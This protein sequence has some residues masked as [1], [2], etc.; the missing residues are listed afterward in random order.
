MNFAE[1][2]KEDY[3]EVKLPTD[4]E[5]EHYFGDIEELGE[6]IKLLLEE[7][8]DHEKLKD[9]RRRLNK[10]GE[11]IS[12]EFTIEDAREALSKLANN[13][14]NF[15][16][17][18]SIVKYGIDSDAVQG[19]ELHKGFLETSLGGLLCGDLSPRRGINGSNVPQKKI[20]SFSFDSDSKK[21]ATYGKARKIRNKVH[22]AE[23]IKARK[24]LECI[25]YLFAAYLF[26]V[27]ENKSEIVNNLHNK[28]KLAENFI[29]SIDTSLP[30]TID[31]TLESEASTSYRDEEQSER[32]KIDELEEQIISRRHAAY[33]IHGNPGAGK[34]TLVRELALRMCRRISEDPLSDIPLPIILHANRYSSNESFTNIICSKLQIHEENLNQYAKQ[35]CLVIFIDGINEIRRKHVR[36]SLVEIE[37]IHSGVPNSVLLITSRMKRLFQGIDFKELRLTPFDNKDVKNYLLRKFEDAEVAKSFYSELLEIPRLMELCRNPLLLY[38]LTDV[39]EESPHVPQ[40]RGRLLNEF[41]NRFLERERRLLTPV[42][43]TTVRRVLSKLAYYMQESDSVALPEIEVESKVGEFTSRFQKGL[44]SVDVMDKLNDANLLSEV[45]KDKLGFFHEMVQEYFAALELKNKYLRDEIDLRNYIASNSWKQVVIFF[46]GILEDKKDEVFQKIREYDIA[47]LAKCVMD[48]PI[49][50]ERQ[51]EEVVEEA[52]QTLDHQETSRSQAIRALAEVWNESAVEQITESLNSSQQVA[53]FVLRLKEDPYSTAADLLRASPDIEIFQ[54]L[55]RALRA[56]PEDE[57]S[58]Q[59]LARSLIT[60]TQE[61]VREGTDSHFNIY[62]LGRLSEFAELPSDLELEALKAISKVLERKA[63][64]AADRLFA[65]FELT[66]EEY[67]LEERILVAAIEDGISPSSCATLNPDGLSEQAR[68]R[69]LMTALLENEPDWV[70]QLSHE[71]KDLDWIQFAQSAFARKMFKDA[72]SGKQVYETLRS[73]SGDQIARSKLGEMILAGEIPV[74]EAYSVAQNTSNTEALANT[75][76]EYIRKATW[77]TDQPRVYTQ[78]SLLADSGTVSEGVV[79]NEIERAR[80]SGNI[81]KLLSLIYLCGNFDKYDNDIDQAGR[82]IQHGDFNLVDEN[83]QWIYCNAMWRFWD[84]RTKAEIARISLRVGAQN[85]HSEVWCS[86][87]LDFAGHVFLNKLNK[88]QIQFR[89]EIFRFAGVEREAREVINSALDSLIECGMLER[90]SKLIYTWESERCDLQSVNRSL[91]VEL[92]KYIRKKALR[93]DIGKAQSV[94]TKWDMGG[95]K[96][97]IRGSQMRLSSNVMAKGYEKEIFSTEE[98]KEWFSQEI[99]EDIN[100]ALS[101]LRADVKE[102]LRNVAA[103]HSLEAIESGDHWKAGRLISAF[104]L[105]GE[106]GPEIKKI[107]PTLVD[108]KKTGTIKSLLGGVGK[109]VVSSFSDLILEKSKEYVHDGMIKEAMSIVEKSGVSYMADEFYEWM[110]NELKKAAISVDYEFILS[111]L[112]E[113]KSWERLDVDALVKASSSVNYEVELKVIRLIRDDGYAFA[114]LPEKAGRVFV[115]ASNLTGDFHT[116]EKGA[117]IYATVELGDE[118]PQ[119]VQASPTPQQSGALHRH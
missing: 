50:D 6:C 69:L 85:L 94:S 65:G 105:Q 79:K 66:G 27:K 92:S 112:E 73:M 54:G 70:Q 23:T 67:A 58:E 104:D 77:G 97:T 18:I 81:A 57:E 117:Y 40:N 16:H 14:E 44:G 32:F 71:D 12:G 61:Y 109:S 102:E 62:H 118:G 4:A 115:H 74:K 95:V 35:N 93:G 96:E 37:S 28:A 51:E 33:G 48:S 41:M 83:S 107:L 119:A 114:N 2:A 30:F 47:L 36:N 22:D 53:D 111:I 90:A 8:K 106:F 52:E 101:I 56:A 38:M 88:G 76:E 1:V 98:I 49:P 9:L 39:S 46:Y 99:E 86:E 29:E 24:V 91:E 108:E 113:N 19:N 3:E 80:V 68:R 26:S 55:E 17:T 72:K 89:R 63:V 110:S 60:L 42:K 34:T 116:L 11:S 84:E 10:A 43:P 7:S 103:V 82:N 100:N 5:G 59:E 13:F 78:I 31:A 87:A 21:S 15:L 64:K 25:E 45:G 20:V 75:A